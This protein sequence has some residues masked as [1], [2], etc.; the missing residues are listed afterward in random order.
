MIMTFSASLWYL[1]CMNRF[2]NSVGLNPALEKAVTPQVSPLFPLNPGCV[3]AKLV[4]QNHGH[5]GP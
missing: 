1:Y 2:Q 5:L 3:Q 4:F